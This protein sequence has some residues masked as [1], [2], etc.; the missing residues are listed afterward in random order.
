MIK[1]VEYLYVDWAAILQQQAARL[2][3]LG[4]C[5]PDTKRIEI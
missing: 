5:I 2:W 3:K 1:D 4:F